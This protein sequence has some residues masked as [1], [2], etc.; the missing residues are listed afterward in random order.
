MSTY[1]LNQNQLIREEIIKILTYGFLITLLTIAGMET[2]SRSSQALYVFIVIVL[3]LT[4]LIII[5][6]RR[7]V[8]L[9]KNS[10]SVLL[11]EKNIYI[12]KWINPSFTRLIPITSILKSQSLSFTMFGYESDV[13][14][15]KM[16]IVCLSNKNKITFYKRHFNSE[17]EYFNFANELALMTGNKNAGNEK[18]SIE[19]FDRKVFP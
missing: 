4:I 10:V 2:Y 12:R 3:T 11:D 7:V 15:S 6:C 16:T 14:K 1:I 9:K 8:Y 13:A 19:K 18:N 5:A 17:M